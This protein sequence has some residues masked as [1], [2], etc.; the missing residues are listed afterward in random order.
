MTRFRSPQYIAIA[1]AVVLPTALTAAV[2]VVERVVVIPDLAMLYLPIVLLVAVYFGTRASLLAAAAATAE[3]DFFFLR[4]LHTL[5][6]QRGEDLIAFCT[7]IFVALAVGR[8]AAGA[9]ERAI[10]A[11]HRA[12]E[13]ATLYEL[14][15]TLMASRDLDTILC[16]IV[17]R[18]V[19]TFAL[20]RCAVFIPG[21]SGEIRRVAESS[22]GTR[23]RDFEAAARYAY[24]QS[25]QVTVPATGGQPGAR[26]I[27]LRAGNHVLGVMELGEKVAGGA[28]SAEENRI[29]TLFAAQ[30]S[31]AIDRAQSDAERTHVQVLKETDRLK[32]ALLSAVSHDLRT[33]LASIK[34]AAAALLMENAAWTEAEGRE[35]LQAIEHESDRLDRLVGNLLDLSRI[36]AGALKPVLDW[37]EAEELV[38][39]IRQRGSSL[40]NGRAFE[41]HVD[42]RLSSLKL[43]LLRIETAILNL[44]ENAVKY[45][46]PGTPIDVKLIGEG[47]A[48][49]VEVIDRGQGV[50]DTQKTLIFDRFFRGRQHSDRSPGTG[51]GL[52]I[53]RGIAEA[54]GGTLDVTDTPGGGATFV[55]TLPEALMPS[56]ATA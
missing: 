41:V 18:I 37:Y 39:A 21:A 8:V 23:G 54:H 36:E 7:F 17:E 22:R 2:G 33:P 49:R 16:A 38:E 29:L 31:L 19:E 32:S 12:S 47:P 48:L 26:Y 56:G 50:S 46:P 10:T 1:T 35:L 11:Q 14:G 4:P 42:P 30:A 53:C 51:L 40:A 44:I 34:A 25:S 28:L 3:Y 15:Q 5:T 6:I 52:T 43:D 20:D 24:V 9:R 13:S 27:P 45:T 55:L